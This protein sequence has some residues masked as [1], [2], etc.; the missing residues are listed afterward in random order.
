MKKF[1]LIALASLMIISSSFAQDSIEE[2]IQ[3]YPNQEQTKMMNT[4]LTK[5]KKGTFNFT[6]L[7]DP[8]DATVVTPQATV[9]YGYNWFSISDAPAIVKTPKYD[10][11]F[12]VSIFDMKH[13][14]PD[15]IVNPEKP[16][17]IIRPGQ[18]VPK[19]DF[20]IVKLETDQGLVFT[21]MVVIDNIDEVSKLGKLIT[22][23]GGKGDMNRNVQRF[24]PETE[25]N[26]LKIIDMVLLFANPDD[27][28]GKV[29][30]D[31]G[32]IIKAAGV[33]GGQLGTPV[34]TVRYGRSDTDDK[35][36]A[37]NGKDT[38][39]VTVPAGLVEKDGYYSVTI[40]G[41][42][43]SLLI[44][45]DKNIYDQTS[46]SSKANSD[47]TYTIT[48]SPSGEGM[49]GIPTGKSFYAVLRAYVPSPNAVMKL[50]IEKQIKH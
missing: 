8:S 48:L 45:N 4:W 36:E 35:G 47:G 38:Y 28:F 22:M 17:L 9:D 6:G 13:N 43:N 44:P 19:G 42:D 21:R 14:I 26:A 3:E 46:Y 20:H 12:S 24:S 39:I 18:K 15:V 30:G 1:Y 40:Y 23:E 32:M 25:K 2:Y 7:V 31:V 10:K 49:N 50:K 16:I 5:H 33:R 29:S 34:E 27:A 11:F 41:K 37:L